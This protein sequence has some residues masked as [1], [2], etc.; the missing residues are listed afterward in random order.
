[1]PPADLGGRAEEEDLEGVVF[2]LAAAFS[3][4][5]D[6]RCKGAAPKAGFGLDCSRKLDSCE[7]AG[8]GEE[9]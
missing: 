9:G 8:R 7:R 5:D 1:M 3:F 2:A 4:K 6:A